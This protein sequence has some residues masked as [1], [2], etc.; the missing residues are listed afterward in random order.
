MTFSRIARIRRMSGAEIVGKC[1]E[2]A[3]YYFSPRR[4][5]RRLAFWL[6]KRSLRSDP[7]FYVERPEYGP[8]NLAVKLQR[9]AAGGP[10]EPYDVTLT[11][12]AAVCLALQFEPASVL[13]I[14]CGTGMFAWSLANKLPDCQIVASEFD[15]LTRHW[16]EENRTSPNI[17][18]CR[19]L[20]SEF[21]PDEFQLV[22]ALEVVEHIADYASFLRELARVAPRAVVSTP[23]KQRSAF[24]STASPPAFDQHVREWTAGEFYWVLRAFWNDVKLYTIP[25]MARQVRKLAANERYSPAFAETGLH[26][27]EHALIAVCALP[28]RS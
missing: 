10:F 23:N 18:Y 15:D 26:C 12:R 9:Q 21:G 28:V 24:D 20:L 3:R 14:G 5:L 2:K 16:S 13:E 4:N 17:R 7:G 22:V 8:S 25:A 11:N 19:S 1:G 27:R 6:D